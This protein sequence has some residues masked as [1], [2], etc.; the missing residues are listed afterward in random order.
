MTEFVI[1]HSRAPH[2]TTAVA[3]GLG[4]GGPSGDGF[5]HL[6]FFRDIFNIKSERFE[7]VETK[8]TGN[9]TEIKLGSPLPNKVELEREDVVT[10]SIPA[11]KLKSFADALAA[12]VA[13]AIPEGSTAT[14]E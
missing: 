7:S 1:K 11:D 13:A 4:L 3:T 10:I 12:H 14:E 2:Y 6:T 8:T 9:A 5:V